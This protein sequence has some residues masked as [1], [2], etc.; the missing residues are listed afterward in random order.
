[1]TIAPDHADRD[2]LRYQ[3]MRDIVEL[4]SSASPC[5]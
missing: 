5:M 3:S 4:H 1:M 2:A